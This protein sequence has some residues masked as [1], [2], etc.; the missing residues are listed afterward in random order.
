[1]TSNRRTRLVT[2]DEARLWRETMRGT[3]PLPGR[4][5]DEEPASPL[6]VPEPVL[7]AP[8]PTPLALPRPPR[9]A[10]AA[11]G[12]PQLDHGRTPGV[13]KNTAERLR[14]GAMAIEAVIDLHGLTQ[15][16]AHATLS[17]FVITS[18]ERGRRCL[19]VITGKGSREGAG[20]LRSQVPRWLN[21]PA[22]RGA[23]LAFAY[24]QP[25]HG[26]QGALYVLLKRRR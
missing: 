19:L 8:P 6:L 16:M 23:V 11:A 22:L 9:P 26:G 2:N 21:E 15:D 12:Q 3:K 5:P 1:M 10:P 4:L 17:R 20:V 7:L 25:K 13:D 14:K 24:A 18:A